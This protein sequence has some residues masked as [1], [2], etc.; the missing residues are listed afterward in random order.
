MEAQM[1][2]DLINSAD[3]IGMFCRLHMNSKRDLPIRPSEMGVLIY[4]QKQSCAVTPL[5]ISQFFNISKPSVSSMVKSLTKQ[6][7]L[8]KESSIADKRSYTLVITE[9]G[10]NLVESTF[11]EYFKAV[12]LLKEKM[13]AEKFDQLVE[14]MEIANCILEKENR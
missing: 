13:G 2:A 7:F 4:A 12:E 1:N 3:V 14:L 5:M 6:G 11:I 9:K 8:I 10:K